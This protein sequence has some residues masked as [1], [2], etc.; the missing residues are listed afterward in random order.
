MIGARC[1]LVGTD[2][3]GMVVGIQHYLG[4]Q[5]RYAVRYWLTGP[6]E[7]WFTA[8]EISFESREAEGNILHID[9]RAA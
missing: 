7:R 5:S 9:R 1:R 2:I 6:Q 4:D 8:G 3:E